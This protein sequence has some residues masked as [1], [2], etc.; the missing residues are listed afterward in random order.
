MRASSFGPGP[1]GWFAQHVRTDRSRG[2]VRS[3]R[4]FRPACSGGFVVASPRAGP[5]QCR[6]LGLRP[7]GSLVPGW[8]ALHHSVAEAAGRQRSGP[9]GRSPGYEAAD[10]K[11]SARSRGLPSV[12][13][14]RRARCPGHEVFRARGVQGARCPGPGLGG[15]PLGIK[16]SMFGHGRT[17]CSAVVVQLGCTAG[18]RCHACR[19]LDAG[20]WTLGVGRQSLFFDVWISM[21]GLQV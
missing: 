6:G 11:V 2:L 1:A 4:L 10:R 14:Y 17:A 18:S 5:W 15:Q 13:R 9:K 8:P 3:A 21:L 7:G 16:T 19:A 12:A 20:S